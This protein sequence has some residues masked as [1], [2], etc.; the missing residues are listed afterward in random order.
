MSDPDPIG[1]LAGIERRA[2]AGAIA[3]AMLV[4]GSSILLLAMSGWFLTSA[5]VAAAGGIAAIQALNYLLPS[6]A[7]RFLAI[8]RTAGRYGERLWSHQAALHA[9]ARLRAR[10]I[11]RIAQAPVTDALALIPGDTTARLIDA[12]DAIEDRV[13]RRPAR[14]AAIAAALCGLALAAL[15][16]PW[17][18]LV[19]AIAIGTVAWG[20]PVLARRWLERPAE[21]AQQVIGLLKRDLVSH[22]EAAADILVYDLQR[23]ITAIGTTQADLYDQARRRIAIGEARLNGLLL[24]IGGIAT[25]GG[26]LLADATPQIIA[27]AALGAAGTIEA[28]AA[29]VRGYAREGM[30]AAGLDRIAALAALP[31]DAGRCLD[32]VGHHLRMTIDGVAHEMAQRDRIALVGRSGAGKTRLI[33]T[34]T[35]LRPAPSGFAVDGID[36]RTCGPR[37]LSRV[38]GLAPQDA[39]LLAGTIADNLRLAR[40]GITEADMIEALTIACFDR[41]LT[42]LPGG[43]DCWIGDDG[44]RLSGGQR[45]RIAI[46]RALLAGRPWLLLDEPSE[47]LD[48]AT[49]AELIVRLKAEIDRRGCGLI[50]ISHRPAMLALAE[51]RIAIVS[52]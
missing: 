16:G 7:I 11:A 39:R 37:D 6:A 51:R 40:P 44:S 23:R 24:I 28:L 30:I 27:L 25:G 15:A 38:F 29:M 43:L 12:I 22:A 14:P 13:V 49:E 1:P 34:L 4:A 5:A 17:P 8:T 50:L 9:T 33:E 52:A 10:L 19:L 42:A 35:G 45:K 41:E 3:A 21:D 32:L 36:L 46:A 48:A 18:P 20:T 2:M 31:A 47:G 26:I